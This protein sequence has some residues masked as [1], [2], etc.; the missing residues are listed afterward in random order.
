MSRTNKKNKQD[1][2]NKTERK[3]RKPEI[4]NERNFECHQYSNA[5]NGPLFFIS[6]FLLN[7]LNVLSRMLI[8]RISGLVS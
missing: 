3:A 4:D 7:E 2:E 6:R 5:L 1:K 8:N